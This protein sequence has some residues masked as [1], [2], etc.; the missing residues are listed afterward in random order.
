MSEHKFK[1]GQTINFRSAARDRAAAAGRYQI[2]AHRPPD[3]GEPCYR[4]YVRICVYR[5]THQV[6]Y[7]YCPP[8]I[9]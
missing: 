4:A 7:R 2:T 9:R 5:R 6:A 8:G 3:D 1:V